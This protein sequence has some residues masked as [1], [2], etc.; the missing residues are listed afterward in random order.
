[1]I[2]FLFS[3]AIRDYKGTK[4]VQLGGTKVEKSSR[5]EL[6]LIMSAP[7][8]RFFDKE[9]LRDAMNALHRAEIPGKTYQLWFKM[10]KNTQLLIVLCL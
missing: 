5:K 1:M 8:L 4:R 7:V 6:I 3:A 10:N 9:N 2:F